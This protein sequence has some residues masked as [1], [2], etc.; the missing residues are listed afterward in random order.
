MTSKVALITIDAI[1]VVCPYC[2]ESQTSPTGSLMWTPQDSKLFYIYGV[3]CDNCRKVFKFPK[4]VQL[5]D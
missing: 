2:K 3:T 5:R 1:A 4:W